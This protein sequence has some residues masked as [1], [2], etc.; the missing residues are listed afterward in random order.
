MDICENCLCTRDEHGAP[1]LLN[2]CRE[3]LPAYVGQVIVVALKSDPNEAHSAWVDYADGALRYRV[4]CKH[5]GTDWQPAHGKI[6]NCATC[7]RLVREI[8]RDMT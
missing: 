8:V 1:G 4:L 7:T 2:G 3:F 5:P 6:H